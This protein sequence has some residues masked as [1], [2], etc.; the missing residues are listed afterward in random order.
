MSMDV[1]QRLLDCNCTVA[2]ILDTFLM[3]I[4]SGDGMKQSFHAYECVALG[5]AQR[6][7]TRCSHV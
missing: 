5:D 2:D 1:I 6:K 3:M 7:R 4:C